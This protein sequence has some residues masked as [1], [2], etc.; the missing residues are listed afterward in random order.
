MPLRSSY[1]QG[2][3][4]WIDLQ[5]PDQE[6][7]KAFYGELFGWTFDDQP[8]PDTDAVY[9]MALKDDGVVGAISAQSAE[10]IAQN[11]PPMWNTYIAVDNVDAAMAR[12]DA[13]GGK[14][15]MPAFDV[16]AAGRMAFVIDPTGAPVGLWQAKE[17]IGA[18]LV[19][20]PG[21]LVWNDLRAD[22]PIVAAAFY[23]AVFGL[24]GD[25]QNWDTTPYISLKV[26]DETVAGISGRPGGEGPS[27]WQIYFAV[28]DTEAVAAKAQALGGTAIVEPTDTPIGPMATLADPQGAVFNVISIAAE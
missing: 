23:A 8:T 13:A 10:S 6:A 19:N 22:D 11:V 27:G 26:G 7:A 16:M 4:N 17:H 12:V 20:E 1:A 21:S 2:T 28:D 15:A 18:T 24:T 25:S 5:T 14:V 9:S 3:P